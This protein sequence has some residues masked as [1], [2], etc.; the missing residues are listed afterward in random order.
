MNTSAIA[1]KLRPHH[2]SETE[3]KKVGI[4]IH[5]ERRG[6]LLCRKCGSKWS[7]DPP[8]ATHPRFRGWWKCPQGCH[9]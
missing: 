6:V 3:L 1:T 2:W 4:E 5:D 9:G 8:P 7:A